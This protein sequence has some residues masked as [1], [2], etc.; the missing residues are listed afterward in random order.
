MQHGQ[1]LQGQN[2]TTGLLVTEYGKVVPGK[3]LLTAAAQTGLPLLQAA[4]KPAMLRALPAPA[5]HA[6]LQLPGR[7]QR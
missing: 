4:A 5:R 7:R 3:W 2:A 1:K 6:A